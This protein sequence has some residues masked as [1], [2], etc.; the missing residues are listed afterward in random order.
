MITVKDANGNLSNT[1]SVTLTSPTQLLVNATTSGNEV[2]IN[3][4]GGT[5]TYFYSIDG[6]N[7]QSSNTFSN[8][9]NGQYIILVKDTNGCAEYE[10]VTVSSVLGAD[11]TSTATKCVGSADGILTITNVNGGTPPFLL[12]L[13]HI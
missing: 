10:T 3:A 6:V 9:I 5:G 11:V 12:S 1:N 4:Q 7:F 8:L 2:I 13:I